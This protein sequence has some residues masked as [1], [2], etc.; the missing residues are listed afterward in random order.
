M[1]KH[2]A[3]FGTRLES[4]LFL[5]VCI[6]LIWIP[7]PGASN[8][9]WSM[10]AW[11]SSLFFLSAIWFLAFIFGVVKVSDG[12]KK[13]WLPALCLVLVQLW[14]FVQW[15]PVSGWTLDSSASYYSLLLGLSYSL[16]FILLLQI[17]N[18]N[19]CKKLLVLVFFS[20]V[21]QAIYGVMM[22]LTGMEMGF[23]VEK[24]YFKSQATGT[25]INPNHFAG[26]LILGLSIGVAVLLDSLKTLTGRGNLLGRSLQVMMSGSIVWRLAL[27]VL[28]VG[29]VMSSSRMG[30]LAFIF[31]LFIASGLYMLIKRRLMLVWIIL[32]ASILVIDT[33]FIG[34]KFGVD[35]LVSE[36]AETVV[37]EE[38]RAS[39]LQ[40]SLPMV[41]DFL[42]LGSGAGS[43]YSLFPM[44]RVEHVG[45]DFY[46]HAHNDY[47]EFIIELGLIGV[48]PLVVFA[49]L[50]FK[51]C[52]QALRRK[53]H[54]AQIAGYAALMSM[55]A[56]GAHS[57]ADFSLRIPAYASTLLAMLAVLH[58]SSH[59]PEGKKRRRK[60][61]F[62]KQS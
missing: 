59:S 17:L 50:S 3:G 2:V 38:E 22:V 28:V 49:I 31:S 13:S 18:A 62:S 27:I 36:V 12:V 10:M 54:W 24:A 34:T 33:V 8:R 45:L 37:L 19:R 14:V 48:L 43:Y 16:L 39:V 1:A 58:Y 26:Y 25:F 21:G 20:A 46:R 41:Q 60:R 56:I 55:F 35:R 5:L 32:L 11:S 61:A 23:F 30:N 40:A 42:W 51:A 6:S 4:L 29:L 9:I 52:Y 53:D 57:M 47:V 7:L 44:Y 15:N